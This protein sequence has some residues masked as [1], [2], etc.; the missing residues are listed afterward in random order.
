MPD[1]KATHSE[2]C[3]RH[4]KA[5]ENYSEIR[6]A[7]LSA[8]QDLL[9]ADDRARRALKESRVDALEPRGS[10]AVD[11]FSDE[12]SYK[13]HE[14]SDAHSSGVWVG[15]GVAA[16]AGA[17]W[18]QLGAWSVTGGLGTGLAGAAKWFGISTIFVGGFELALAPLVLTCICLVAGV[19]L[20]V[21]AALMTRT[22][23]SRVG[24][25]MGDA[26]TAMEGAI[27]R[28]EVN[29]ARLRELGNHAKDAANDI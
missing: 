29:G 18:V 16:L 24:R 21:A 23:R 7:A 19:S 22:R 3:S 25:D 13:E 27:E 2:L 5:G 9:D 20:L 28:M 6:S 8:F 11:W 17:I 4:R 10:L 26:N 12:Q 15:G 14:I 1:L